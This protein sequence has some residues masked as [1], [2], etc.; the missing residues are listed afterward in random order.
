MRTKIYPKMNIS[1]TDLDAL[2][3]T[4]KITLDRSDYETKV[5]TVLSD[6]RKNANIPGF[7]KGNVP[8]GMIKKQY[9]KAVTADEI[10]K[11][12]RENLEK[13]I[14]EEKIELL[15]NPLPKDSEE[16]LDWSAEQLD[17]EFE[18]GLAP[19]F[20]VKLDQLKKVIRYEIDPEAKMV[21]EQIDYITNQYGKLVSQK[22][23]K[24][25]YE[26]T[27]QFRNEALEIE[28]MSTFKLDDLKS[29]KAISSLESETTNSVLVF[30]AKGLFKENETL[31]RALNLDEDQFNELSATSITLELKE[32][33]E[34][35]PAE[36]NQELFDK[37]Y[38]EGTVTNE[39]E[40]KEKVKESLQKQFEPQADQKL[41]NDSHIW[42]DT[43]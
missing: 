16:E 15:G 12:L 21:N 40:L 32:I 34:R 22:N 36:L 23:P 18:L 43:N 11:L 7:R 30:P 27:A 13:F 2:N 35:I 9:E 20:E 42:S 14:R 17:F 38:P 10:N 29:K 31:K 26:I 33:N 41:L 19:Q 24:K 39:K 4:I 5:N 3:A 1:K 25:G 37:L 8:M 28:K 6:Y